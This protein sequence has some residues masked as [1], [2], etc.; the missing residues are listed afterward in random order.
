[1]SPEGAPVTTL[2][3]AW[4]EGDR[5]ALDRLMPIVYDELRRIASGYLRGERAGHTFRPTELVAEAYLR[6]AGANPPDVA[7]RVHFFAVAAR[8]MRQILVDHARKRLRDK[9]G[10]GERVITFDEAL[11][12]S[13][14]SD[15]LVAL[16]EALDAL[17]QFDDRKARVV[18]LHYFG[19]LTQAEI[20]QVLG[21]HVNTVA[22][23]LKLATAWIHR[24]L[25]TAT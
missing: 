14:R 4:R 10:G 2:L 13:E 12:G 25:R 3:R 21:V 16:D 17:A 11:V 19:G 18:E 20:A 8:N 9:R 23:D 22:N 1:V 5:A 6:L 7:D 15:E 24:H